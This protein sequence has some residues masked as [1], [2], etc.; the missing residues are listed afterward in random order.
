MIAGFLRRFVWVPFVVLGCSGKTTDST[1]HPGG[2]CDGGTCPAPGRCTEGATKPAGDGCN[3]CTCLDGD[4]ACTLRACPTPQCDEGESKKIDCNTCTCT[5]GRWACTLV[6]C[7]PP[8]VCTDGQTMPAPDGCN[9]CTCA[10][11]QWGCTEK[12]C[13]PPDCTP[14]AMKPAGDGCNTCS[15]NNGVWLCTLKACPAPVCMNGDTRPTDECN[16]CTCVNGQWS[17]CT[18]KTCPAPPPGK[19]CGGWLGNTCAADEY[20]AYT[21][22]L[23][24]GAADASATCKPRPIECPPTTPAPVCGCDGKQYPSECAAA[25]AGTGVMMKGPCR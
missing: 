23:L 20:C 4:W 10:N 21:E 8:P 3:S 22:G 24:C 13:I 7:Q 19:G 5:D 12:A 6:D 16:T 17:A 9:T 15:C 18:N 14:G 11:G 25:Y 1:G 2:E